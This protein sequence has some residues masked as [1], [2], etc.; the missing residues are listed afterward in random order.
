L[1]ER[2]KVL[3]KG[4]IT[5]PVKMRQRLGMKEGDFVELEISNNKLIVLPPNTVANPT[6]LLMSLGKGIVLTEPLDQ[7]IAKAKAAVA[8]RKLRGKPVEVC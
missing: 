8:A 2:V 1:G 7:E 5:I 4:K 3:Q 6:E